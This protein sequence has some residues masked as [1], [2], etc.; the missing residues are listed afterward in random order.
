[1]TEFLFET[2]IELERNNDDDHKM[3]IVAPVKGVNR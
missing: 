1:M 3:I 2:V